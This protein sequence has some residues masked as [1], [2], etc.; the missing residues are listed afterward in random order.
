M[1]HRLLA[2]LLAACGATP[3]PKPPAN[4]VPVTAAPVT[5][6]PSPADAWIAKLGDPRESER[7]LSQLEQ[8][9]DP[10]AIG[11]IGEAWE[12]QGRQARYLQVAIA[13]ARPL[14]PAE[15]KRQFFTDYE[16]TGRPASW[17]KALP[18]LRRAVLELDPANPRA[19]DSA[20]KAADALGEARLGRES[21]AT[22][23]ATPP[24]KQT[25]GAVIA[26]IRALG[27]FDAAAAPALVAIVSRA[28]PPHGNEEHLALYL[29]TVGSAVN[30]LGQ[31]RTD[32]A[33]EPLVVAMY[34]T[35]ELMMQ[36]RRALAA[37]G[38]KV[39]DVLRKVLRG[40][41]AA[42]EAL[43]VDKSCDDA[44]T[45]N[46]VGAHDFYAAL[47]LGDLHD[48]AAIPDL[49]AAWKRPPHPVYYA[50]DQ[51]SPNTQH[52]ALADALRKLGAPDAEA[53]MRAIWSGT[54]DVE[55]RVLALG[56]YPFVARDAAAAPALANLVT[57]PK[58]DDTLRFEAAT[59]LARVSRDPKD[60]AAF[61]KLAKKYLDA[62]AAKA[63]AAQA[64][65]P[66]AAAADKAYEAAKTKAG[67]DKAALRKAK[68]AHRGAVA[69]YKMLARAAED[70][71][72]FARAIQSHAAR[73]E[74]AA[75]CKD[76]HACFA[77]TLALTSA[78]ELANLA[79]YVADIASWSDDDKRD[80][81]ATAI[82]RAMLELG[83]LG[84]AATAETGALLAAAGSDAH[85]V[86]Q[87]IL[88]ALPA[89][90]PRP[91]EACVPAL[92]QVIAAGAGKSALADLQLETEIERNYFVWAGR[93]P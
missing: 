22:L 23:A 67:D 86:R 78:Q 18:T 87:S 8:L 16:T 2:L 11:A 55:L 1:T 52:N 58:T 24:T 25:I 4:S 85:L 41:D 51:P 34:R 54:G 35:P 88:L 90:A 5:A 74:V 26:A 89:I 38:P 46:P 56:V 9:G 31:L 57:D 64:R 45:C 62:S 73:I 68:D 49:L 33:I 44:G 79:P 47:V 76:D 53:P 12:A 83:K 30:A 3:A 60:L 32:A 81:L 82:E 75:R 59:A 17:D 92:D 48:R 61:G 66:A 93:R 80:L 27:H 39:A 29:A 28:R 91:C 77:A 14:T 37:S 65:Q 84:P 43:H 19:V 36:L 15:A 7:A 69:E 50:D 72:S 40:E 21:L 20:I 6:P 10:R 13:L 63:K 70:Y 71:K 42:V